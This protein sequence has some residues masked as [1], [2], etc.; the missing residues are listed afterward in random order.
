MEKYKLTIIDNTYYMY[1][2]YK[3][4][5]KLIDLGTK[6]YNLAIERAERYI[7]DI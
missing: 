4:K 7:K 3:G 1:F 2:D 6:N 5:L